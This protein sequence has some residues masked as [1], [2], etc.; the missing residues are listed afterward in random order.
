MDEKE[1]KRDFLEQLIEKYW[2]E[3]IQMDKT[4]RLAGDHYTY[5]EKRQYCSWQAQELEREHLYLVGYDDSSVRCRKIRDKVNKEAV[6]DHIKFLESQYTPEYNPDTGEELEQGCLMRGG[7]EDG[8]CSGP[9]PG[10]AQERLRRI[11]EG[12]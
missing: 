10:C 8:F 3:V 1:I 9:C 11:R 7:G 5:R 6:E 2:R 12:K 4:I